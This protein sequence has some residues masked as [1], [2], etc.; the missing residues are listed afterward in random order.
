METPSSTM[1]RVT[2]SQASI[3]SQK[4][5]KE[6]S[7]TRS[8]LIDITNDSPIIGLATTTE[9]TPSSSVIK[10]RVRAKST[11]GSGEALLRGQVKSLLQKVEEEAEFVNKVYSGERP[12]FRVLLGLPGPSPVQVLAPTPA[13]TPLVLS[14]VEENASKNAPIQVAEAVKPEEPAE[15][16]INRALLFD[17][18]EKSEATIDSTSSSSLSHQYGENRSCTEKSPEYDSSSAWSTQVNASIQDEDED[19]EEAEDFDGEGYDDLCEGLSK[20]TV[21][22]FFEGKHTRFVY[23]SDGEIEGE[24]VVNEEGAKTVAASPG[25]VVLKGLPVPEG[26]HLRFHDEEEEEEEEDEEG[27]NE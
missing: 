12:P 26:K 15:C 1:R 22:E 27:T 16:M 7:V 3:A 9:K 4:T 20:M 17:S 10:N 5:K 23:N 19:E 14:V 13:N 11:P 2:R 25:V 24:E 6:D 18:P 21:E 8:A